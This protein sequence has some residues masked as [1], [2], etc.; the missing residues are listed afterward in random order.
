MDTYTAGDFDNPSNA[1]NE[2][3]HKETG[4]NEDTNEDKSGFLILPNSKV[5]CPSQSQLPIMQKILQ[6]CILQRSAHQDKS[7]NFIQRIGLEKIS[8]RWGKIWVL[9]FTQ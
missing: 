2:N 1:D 8:Q 5:Q 6:K 9:A 3:D 7:W 4:G